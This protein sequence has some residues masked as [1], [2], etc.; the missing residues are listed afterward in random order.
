MPEFPAFPPVYWA[1]KIPQKTAIIW[2]RGSSELFSFLPTE[3]SWQQLNILL[4]QV[5]AY[6]NSQHGHFSHKTI[7]YCGKNRF[8]G[9][10]CYL[11]V[12]A[13]GGRIL[14]LNPAFTSKQKEQILADNV[15]DVLLQD[16]DFVNFSP[17]LTACDLAY[18]E[19]WDKALPATLTLTSGSSGNPK[20][21]V[22][23][24]TAHLLNAEGVCQLMEFEQEHSW[25]LCLP[26][27]H[28]SGQGIIWRWLVKGAML[29]VYEDK[30]DFY[31]VLAKSSHASLVPTQLYRYLADDILKIEG[32]KILLGGSYIPAELITS[33]KQA[34]IK[35]FSGYGMTEMASTICAI[36]NEIDNVGKPLFGREVKIECDQIFVK[37]DCLALG[38]W[39]NGKINPFTDEN[40]YFATKDKGRFLA[41]GNLVV[42][43]RLDNMFISGGE[44]IQPEQIESVLYSS[45][46]V[47]NVF[48]IPFDDPEFG[49]RPVAFVEFQQSFNEQAVDKLRNFAKQ[50]LERF[51]QPVFYFSLTEYTAMSVGIKISRLGL[52]RYLAQI[53]NGQ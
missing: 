38:Y 24:C 3:L 37:S 34:G 40:G 12:I 8:V 23:N 53:I 28:V 20:A 51:K 32:Q 42:E 49:Q 48:V 50:H 11:C 43:G 5:L 13:Q 22:H 4:A 9:L 26:L 2:E 36:A 39:Q 21:A 25:L 46:I 47:Q 6:L 14:M 17:K 15:I 10:L 33:A 27:F 16:A 52:Q 30:A 45:G 44:N 29:R 41:N 7:S 19:N 1:K 18:G 31:T 35:I